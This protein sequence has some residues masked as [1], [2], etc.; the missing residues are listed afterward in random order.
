VLHDY[1][2]GKAGEVSRFNVGLG[3]AGRYALNQQRLTNLGT[4]RAYAVSYLAALPGIR[5]DMTL[6]V[7]Q[8]DARGEGIPL[9]LY[10]FTR[11]TD[12]YEYEGIVSDIFDHMFAVLP[13]F[14]LRLYQKPAGGD[15]RDAIASAAG[16]GAGAA[17]A[18]P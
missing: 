8:L 6:L 13:E 4:L 9:E 10:C 2:A 5:K 3:E 14:G 12:W 7:R 16:R 1:L 17:E 11:T 15:L 18:K